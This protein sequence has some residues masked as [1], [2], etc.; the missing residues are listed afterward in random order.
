MTSKEDKALFWGCWIALVT[1]SFA[2]IARAFTQDAWA[3]EFGL[4]QTQAGEIFG[5][6]LWPFAISI[7][8]FSLVMDKIGYKTAMI[9]GFKRPR[10][11][12][13]RISGLN[14]V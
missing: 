4:S 1:T 9:F 10:S 8:L 13:S 11:A 12:Y 6:G 2:F 3:A 5:A 7:I 14:W